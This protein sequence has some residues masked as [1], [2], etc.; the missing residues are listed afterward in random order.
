[1]VRIHEVHSLVM[2][3]V[4]M[5]FGDVDSTFVEAFDYAYILHLVVEW[6]KKMDN[7]K[8]AKRWYCL[9]TE[10]DCVLTLL[11]WNEQQIL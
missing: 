3:Y 8:N 1:M 9:E 7:S 6:K 2:F 5:Q 4:T 10:H 11:V